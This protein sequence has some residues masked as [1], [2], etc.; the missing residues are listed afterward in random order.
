MNNIIEIFRY[1]L[2]EIK[3]IFF[4]SKLYDLTNTIMSLL[5]LIAPFKYQFQV[6]SVLPKE[7]YNFIETISPYIF[8]INESYDEKFFEKNAINLEDT[9]ICAVDIDQ[10][11]YYIITAYDKSKNEVIPDYPK[12]LREKIEKDYNNYIQDLI[13]KAKDMNLRKSEYN[14]INNNSTDVKEDNKIYQLIFFDFMI[15]LL[16]D[17]PKFLSKDYGVSRDISMSVKDMIDIPAYLNSFNPNERDFY[18]RIFNTQMFIEF[19]FKR[20]MPK[21]CN[22]KVEILFFEEKI[23]EKLSSKK[24]FGKSKLRD[25]NVLLSS[26]EYNYDRESVIIDCSKDIGITEA[27]YDYYLNNEKK[28]EKEFNSKGYDIEIDKKNNKIL[29]KYHIFPSLLSEQ[30]FSLN[31]KYYNIPN[32]YYKNI[33]IINASIVN[34]SHLKFNNKSLTISE[35]GNDLY[36]CY[37]IVWALTLWYTDTWE[38]EYRFLKMIEIIEKVERHEIEIFELLFK[39]I[40]NYC[41]DKDTVLLYKKFIHLNLNPSWSI[42]SLVSKIIKKKSNIK[43]KKVLLSQQTKFK[44]LKSNNDMEENKSINEKTTFR[45]RTLKVREID[46]N[47]LSEDL[48]LNAY[49]YCR[50][51]ND[52][53]NL[54]NLCS[55]LVQLNTKTEKG[56]D[57][58]QCPNKHLKN[59][60]DFIQIKLNF[61]FGV[62]LFNLK[63]QKNK[64]FSTSNYFLIDLLSPSTIKKN[65]LKIAKELGDNKFNVEM[66][67]KNHKEI[68]W[69]L[70]WFFVLNNMDISFMLPYLDEP[71]RVDNDTHC[72][73]IKKCVSLKIRRDQDIDIEKIVKYDNLDVSIIFY[74]NVEALGDKI[75]PDK[76]KRNIFTNVKKQYS[77]NDIVKQKIY[78]LYYSDKTGM[79]S[80]MGL[81]TFS[82]NIG[83]NEYPVQFE[84]IQTSAIDDF[85]LSFS[86]GP[87]STVSQ[88]KDF[89]AFNGSTSSLSTNQTIG[90]NKSISAK[91]VVKKF[92]TKKSVNFEDSN[93]SSNNNNNNNKGTNILKTKKTK[94]GGILKN[95]K[96][97]L[98][99]MSINENI[100]KKPIEEA[101]F[102][103]KFKETLKKV[104]I[105]SKGENN[106]NIS[107][108]L[109]IR[110]STLRDG[111]LYENDK[112]SSDNYEEEEN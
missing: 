4:S 21:D 10:D 58:F 82:D 89:N 23:N 110:K 8:G 35:M 108:N 15:F 12:H 38:R 100:E 28:A 83:Y 63:L 91:Q 98:P 1:L 66:F 76:I 97:N 61:T 3:M 101:D 71:C 107:N 7:L 75:D 103:S 22:E 59:K 31:Y 54:K 74:G 79:I 16:K 73:K 86:F 72:E 45:S 5:T 29:F 105:E 6:V 93:N 24:L 48:I 109:E 46:D 32:Q 64:K 92:I 94:G 34:K 9:T 44:D 104:D 13:S 68:F 55:D 90:P 65:L 26:K 88:L 18:R 42:F 27:V 47:V 87:S 69:N 56:K 39:A 43:N 20:M 67:K 78:Q 36:L 30:F 51:C 85:P 80:Y 95:S 57:F 53:I 2:F 33:D 19:I 102:L 111:I 84:I 41:K 70:V 112:D 11:K 81:D 106:Y 77:M 62:E 14:Y 52:F 99:I 25:Q 40:V 17:Y 96:K 50:Y 49:V 37:L 60:N